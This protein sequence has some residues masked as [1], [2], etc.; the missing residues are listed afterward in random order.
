MTLDTLDINKTALIISLNCEN[1]LRRRLLD[2]GLVPNTNVTALFTS[3]FG[4]PVAYSVR[5]S[6]IALRKED[7]KFIKILT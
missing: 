1:N 6:I 2:L 4:N 7:S 3:P 5:G